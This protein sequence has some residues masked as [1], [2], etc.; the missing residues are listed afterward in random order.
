MPAE[1]IS[2]GE[3]K[4]GDVATFYYSSGNDQRPVVLCLNVFNGLLHAIN[5]NYLS[6]GQLAYLKTMLGE[7]MYTIYNIENPKAFYD[8]V[9]KKANLAFAYRTYKPSNI[10]NLFRIGYKAETL[11]KD[12]GL[13]PKADDLKPT[14]KADEPQFNTKLDIPRVLPDTILTDTKI[15]TGINTNPITKEGLYE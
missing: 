5:L 2:I 7:R 11:E 13:R 1:R 12:A 10:I 9:L 3:L 4:K 6:V 15:N 14:V 8:N